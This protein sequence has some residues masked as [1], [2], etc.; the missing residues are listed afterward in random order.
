MSEKIC[1][2]FGAGNEFPA[3]MDI[4][5]DSLI[6]AADGGLKKARE[7]SLDPQYIVGDLDSL[8]SCPDSGNFRLL[9][10]EKD[11]TDTYEAVRYALEHGCTEFRIY[12]GTGGR[13]DHTLAN[14]QLAAELSQKGMKP[15]IY[16]DRYVLT[17]LTNGS[18][19]LPARDGGYVSVFAHSEICS[20]VT[21]R[22]LYYEIENAELRSNFALGVSNEFTGKPSEICVTNGT[23][24]I[25]YETG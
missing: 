23:L 19:S 7:L 3:V 13:L 11:T 16:G 9:P 25:Y 14:I 2:I 15:L 10:H 5:R 4:P 17:A 12:G 6:I 1:V 21:I 22:G 24:I 8:E 20:G 18:I